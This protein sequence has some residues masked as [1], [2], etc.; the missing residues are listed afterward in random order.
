MD[1][2]ICGAT[3]SGGGGD[4][5]GHAGASGTAPAD[6]SD[7]WAAQRD[8]S[9]VHDLSSRARASFLSEAPGAVQLASA[10]V[11]GNNNG[12]GG[13]GGGGGDTSAAAVAA[14]ANAAGATAA[15]GGGSP[16][17]S[18]AGLEPGDPREAEAKSN[19][20]LLVLDVTGV[21]YV[22]L[23]ANVRCGART[24]LAGGGGGEAGGRFCLCASACL[25]ACVAGVCARANTLSMNALSSWFLLLFGVLPL[26]LLPLPLLRIPDDK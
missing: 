10:T 8:H 18:A 21:D 6:H 1:E 19:F 26:L 9:W 14:G 2:G 23:N 20:V 13:G 7:F 5:G 17:L 4:G 22:D 3:A 24:L 25:R 15:S 12:G 11:L 16:P